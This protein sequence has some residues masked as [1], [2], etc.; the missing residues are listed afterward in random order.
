MDIKIYQDDQ[1]VSQ[2]TKQSEKPFKDLENANFCASVEYTDEDD[3][4]SAAPVI[5]HIQ[6]KIFLFFLIEI[7]KHIEKENR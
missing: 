2:M 3:G 7:L 5:K 4:C 1:L 6:Y